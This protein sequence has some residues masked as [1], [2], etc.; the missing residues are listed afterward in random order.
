LAVVVT[1]EEPPLLLAVQRITG[2]IEV[3]NDLRRP[4]AIICFDPA[5]CREAMKPPRDGSRGGSRG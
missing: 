2:R 4:C 3:K 5:A 1:V